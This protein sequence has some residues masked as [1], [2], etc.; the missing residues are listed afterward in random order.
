M[1]TKTNSYTKGKWEVVFAKQ[2]ADVRTAFVFIQRPEGYGTKEN[3][4]ICQVFAMGDDGREGEEMEANA[5]LISAAPDLLEACKKALELVNKTLPK[6]TYLGL[7]KSDLLNA[8]HKA[9]N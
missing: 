6:D 3:P 5:R 8:I 2:K 7:L 1:E 4:D 9:E